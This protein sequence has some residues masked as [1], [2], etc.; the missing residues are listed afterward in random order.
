MLRESVFQTAITQLAKVMSHMQL[1]FSEQAAEMFC[2]CCKVYSVGREEKV[3]ISN[4]FRTRLC[5]IW[6]NIAPMYVENA[7]SRRPIF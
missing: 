3:H 7:A 2:I 5:G 6:Y 1:T 4:E